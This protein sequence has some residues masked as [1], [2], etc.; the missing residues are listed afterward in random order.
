MQCTGIP[1]SSAPRAALITPS[2]TLTIEKGGFTG[3][4]PSI[5]GGLLLLSLLLAPTT[6]VIEAAKRSGRTFAYLLHTPRRILRLLPAGKGDVKGTRGRPDA[7]RHLPPCFLLVDY[8]R[9]AHSRTG[10]VSVR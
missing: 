1:P 4:M 10:T 7:W 2:P 6:I 5:R 3:F 9:R 8:V